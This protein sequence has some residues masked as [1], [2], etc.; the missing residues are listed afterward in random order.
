MRQRRV[1][2]IEDEA[3]QVAAIKRYLSQHGYAVQHAADGQTGVIAAEQWL[4]DLVLMDIRLPVM[5]GFDA[6]AEIRRR[7]QTC[8]IPIVALTGND[9]PEDYLRGLLAGFSKYITKPF[10]EATLIGEVKEVISHS[11]RRARLDALAGRTDIEELINVDDREQIFVGLL[12][13]MRRTIDCDIFAIRWWECSS[14][15]TLIA[16]FG[17]NLAE[18]IR[19]EILDELPLVSDDFTNEVRV[20]ETEDRSAY[21]DEL[22][23]SFTVALCHADACYGELLVGRRRDVPFTE[24]DRKTVIELSPALARVCARGFD[25]SA[26]KTADGGAS[27]VDEIRLLLVLDDAAMSDTWA[28]RV[29]EAISGVRA[30]VVEGLDEVADESGYHL[31]VVSPDRRGAL[32]QIMFERARQGGAIFPLL[33]FYAEEIGDSPKRLVSY[34]FMG[35]LISFMDARRSGCLHVQRRGGADVG[36]I[37]FHEGRIAW[38]RHQRCNASFF[39]ILA[40][41]AGIGSGEFRR[42]VRCSLAD[43]KSI[44]DLLRGEGLIDEDGFRAALKEYL[45][46]VVGELMRTEHP[47]LLVSRQVVAASHN[48]SFEVDD[49]TIELLAI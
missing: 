42:L 24:E 36:M 1:L 28:E 47:R 8:R 17:A 6:A 34:L 22:H 30:R 49:I 39:R 32:E 10:D 11:A 23:Y 7:P 48:V 37:V 14:A 21:D 12:Q 44:G 20:I 31:A 16:A 46:S 13:A 15:P 2:I 41:R 5:N 33:D 40:A 3:A 19:Q 18:G 27:L 9:R 29:E 4:P 35:L 45:V 26:D 43:G 38:A 25:I